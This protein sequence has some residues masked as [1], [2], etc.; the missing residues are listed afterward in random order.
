MSPAGPAAQLGQ[1]E[2]FVLILC[3]P[4]ACL[5]IG[6]EAANPRHEHPGFTCDVAADVPAIAVRS[7][8]RLGDLCHSFNPGSFGVGRG[9]DSGVTVRIHGPNAVGDPI[10]LMFDT[11]D[12][13]GEDRRATRTL[14][15]EQVGE[16]CN[17]QTEISVG[18]VRPLLSD[19]LSAK[20]GDVDPH[21]TSRHRIETSGTHDHIEVVV[22]TGCDQT[23]GSEP[24][25]TGLTHIDQ[26]DVAAVVGFEVVGASAKPL[27]PKD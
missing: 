9:L 8:R 12:H 17:P 6:G 27:A 11:R 23:R 5:D 19:G 15:I 21:D 1:D 22:G 7:K 4:A 24:F 18:T 14:H 16:S 20:P 13:R 3:D 2:T 10:T 25:D 26:A